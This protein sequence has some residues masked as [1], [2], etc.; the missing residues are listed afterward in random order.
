MGNISKGSNIMGRIYQAAEARGFAPF[1]EVPELEG[2]E[3]DDLA[4]FEN[5][6]GLS[7]PYKEEYLEE[8]REIKLFFPSEKKEIKIRVVIELSEKTEETFLL[9]C[10]TYNYEERFMTYEPISIS[11]TPKETGEVTHY[12]DEENVNRYLKE[13]GIT[14]EDIA[15]YQHYAL[16]DVVV[17]TWV[18][19]HGGD[20]DESKRSMEKVKTFDNTYEFTEE[21]TKE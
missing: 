17:R 16:Y 6:G 13:F 21:G 5:F 11:D 19:T 12:Y 1:N 3:Y 7:I 15:E 14:K 18:K 4:Q 9:M 20:Y 2:L 10:M 8:N